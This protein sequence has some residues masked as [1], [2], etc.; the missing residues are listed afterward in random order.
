MAETAVAVERSTNAASKR[1]TRAI[2]SRRSFRESRTLGTSGRVRL[3]AACC[4]VNTLLISSVDLVLTVELNG[5]YRK[6]R[7]GPH[8]GKVD[9]EK[10]VFEPPLIIRARR[11]Q[12]KTLAQRFEVR[13]SQRSSKD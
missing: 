2:G 7:E 4:V 13:F 8:Y 6:V 9:V 11:T 10:A 3:P 1:L 5:L 12:K